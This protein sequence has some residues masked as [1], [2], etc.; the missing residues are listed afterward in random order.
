MTGA[1]SL[2]LRALSLAGKLVLSLY[3]AK[4][5]TL[6]ELGRYGLAFGAV[7]FATAAF[8]FK[9]D[10]VV[11]REVLGLTNRDSRRI[12]STTLAIFVISFLA[13]APIAIWALLTFGDQSSGA[14]FVIVVYLLC[15]VEAYANFLYT[16]T[17]ALKRPG[18]ANALFFVRSGLWTIPAIGISYFVPSLRNVGF[19]LLCWLVGV[20]LSVLLN[21]WAT[22]ARLFGWYRWSDLA[23]RKAHQY[24]RRA[25]L[26]WIGS[27]GLTLGAYVD[28]FV[29]ATYM[30]LSDVGI[31]TFYLSFTTSVLTLVQSATTNVTFPMLI[32]HYDSGDH[33]S[34][35]KEL[36]KMGMVAGALAAAILLP[37]AVAMPFLARAMAKPALVSSYPAF[38]LLLLATFIRISA[39]TI[40]YALFVHRQHREIWLGNL[41]FL[42][43]AFGLNILL[44]PSFGLNGLG[45]AALV[46]A[47]ALFLWRGFFA[48][49][50]HRAELAK[51]ER[52]A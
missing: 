15:C 24:I 28:R 26:V 6:A 4:F 20:S 35:D 45:I 44:I 48:L 39:E 13:A 49:R 27:V 52:F 34:Y 2:G 32:E 18:L 33:R 41:L 30:T 37:L 1:V 29:L 7:M 16:T 31:A 38:L 17:I 47:S 5:F 36:R 10:Y 21:L 46:A 8:G 9:L 23:W 51:T 22:R 25:L 12:G 43:V 50:H 11:S 3:M 42:A 19:V 14:L 40:Y